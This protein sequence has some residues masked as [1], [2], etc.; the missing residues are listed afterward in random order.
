MRF[1]KLQVYGN[2][3]VLIDERDLKPENPSKLA[4]KLLERRFSVG[5]D[6]L[7]LVRKIDEREYSFRYFN[8]DGS[9]AEICGNALLSIGKYLDYRFKLKGKIRI[10]TKAGW[11][12]V[13]SG[14]KTEALM[15]K[16]E[17]NFKEVKLEDIRGF[18][19]QEMGNPHF[20]LLGYIPDDPEF[21]RLGRRIENH[22]FFPNRTNV[23]F[24]RIE[25][26]VSI[27]ARSWERGIGETL[28]CSSGAGS[29]FLIARNLKLVD[30]RVSV[31]F[32]GG[33]IE[34]E[35]REGEIIIKGSPQLVFEG[36]LI[37]YE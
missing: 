6:G 20:V 17:G 28:S 10:L 16:I 32:R 27:R 36:K 7:L 24:A 29:I 11:R 5:G 12:W 15:G 34:I 14:E 33:V 26:K 25:T 23:N 8:P 1:F 35:E 19:T 37:E 4:Q 18:F 30:K 9:E 31:C 2:D 22:P 13:N 21:E 3:F